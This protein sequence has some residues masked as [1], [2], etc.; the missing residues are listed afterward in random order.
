M[1]NRSLFTFY[2]DKYG[3][4]NINLTKANTF[5]KFGGFESQTE[6]PLI[7]IPPGFQRFGV[8]DSTITFHHSERI[9]VND[10]FPITDR[11]SSVIPAPQVDPVGSQFVDE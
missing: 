8:K 3:S 11:W 6:V 4:A 2:G 7:P 9:I 1:I 10:R 5:I